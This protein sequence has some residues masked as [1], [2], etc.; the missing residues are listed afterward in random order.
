MSLA[1]LKTQTFGVCYYPEH[2]P[3][4]RWPQDARMM[5][6]AGI[7]FV[8]IGEFAWSLM[9]PEPGEYDFAWLERSIE[10]LAAEGLKVVLGT[11]T[12]TPPKWLVDQMPDMFPVGKD[13]RV[14]GFGS[15]RH[16]CFSHLGY[17]DACAQITREMAVRFGNHPA[18]VAWQTDNEY[19]CH[20]TVLSYSDAAKTGFRDWLAQKYQ[21][22]DALNKAW[23]T[24]F[25]SMVYRSIDEVELPNGAV[26]ETNPIHRLDFHRYASDQ[27]VAFNKVQSDIL[28]KYSPGRAVVHNFMGKFFDFDHYA[29]SEDLDISSWDAY[30]LGFLEREIGDE[31][32]LKRHM[33]VGDPDFDPFHHDLYRACGQM[34]NGTENGRWWVM[35]QQ[36]YGPLNW[37]TFNH[38]P[39]KGAGRLWVWEAFAAGAE[40]VSFFRWRQPHFGQEQMHEGLLLP[41]GEPN[42]GYE[43][44][45]EVS[46][47]LKELTPAPVQ[48]QSE[49]ALVF[50]YESQWM[51]GYQA[52]GADAS[53]F[54]TVMRYYR[55]LRRAG[56]NVDIVPARSDAIAGRKLVLIPMLMHV[57]KD[58]VQALADTECRVIAGPWTGAKTEN[59]SIPDTLAPGHLQSLIDIAV[60][61]IETR[62]AF[63][64]IPLEGGGEFQGWR[65]FIIAGEGVEVVQKTEDGTP[66]ILRNGPVTYVAGRLDADSLDQLVRAEMDQAGIEWFDMPQDIR[67]RSNGDFRVVFNYGKSEV[68]VGHLFGL[69]EQIQ[70]QPADAIVRKV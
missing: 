30:P 38:N 13:G 16:Y 53:H 14:R 44:C 51:M 11:P 50:D 36:P 32:L 70:I 2:W 48:D 69:G 4:E 1:P 56:V 28:R 57:S 63:S 23:G 33:G 24:V 64:P 26:T 10:V 3:E 5:R 41:N 52:H 27:V 17:R 8:R 22:V 67:M 34:R 25:W 40:V 47:E 55:S 61:R 31:E 15:R 49:V 39:E 66:A 43:L 35:E 18:V 6:E 21:S 46:A 19:G 7:E 62:R 42:F 29:L 59:F 20:N 58:F 60:R 9:E 54:D 65:E 68:E 45:K 12:A 37:G